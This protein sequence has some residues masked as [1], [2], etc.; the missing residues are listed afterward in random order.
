MIKLTALFLIFFIVPI[1]WEP[2]F[3]HAKKVAKE[4]HQLILL[5]FSGSDWCAPCIMLRKDYLESETFQQMAETNLIMVNADFPRKKKNAG[6]PETIKR[7]EA[8]AEIYNQKGIFPCTMLLDADGKVLK[9]WEGKPVISTEE[10]T[11]QI[12]AI[13]DANRK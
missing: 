5:N 13:C 7:N 8:L 6:T 4:K 12:K 2:D 3:E 9:V 10:W 11:A 1:Q